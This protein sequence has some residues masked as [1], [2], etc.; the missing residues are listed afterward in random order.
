MGHED[1]NSAPADLES[2]VFTVVSDAARKWGVN[3]STLS[4]R[5]RH[6]TTSRAQANSDYRQCLT[7]AQEEVLIYRINY[8][9][10]R[11]LSP[12]PKIVKSLAEEI[13]GKKIG[14]NWV[15]G[16]VKRYPDRLLSK[17][18]KVMDKNR[19]TQEY[20]PVFEDFYKTV[21]YFFIL[22]ST[23]VLRNTPILTS[24]LALR[25]N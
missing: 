9:T 11:N 19:A 21:E 13:A 4:K 17:Y 20:A 22:L 23:I 7:N 10:R 12:I 25:R 18:L 24:L 15:D 16:F 8:L 6:K 1:I 3:R 2:G 14:K 5:F